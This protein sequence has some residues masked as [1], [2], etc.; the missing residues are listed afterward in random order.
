MRRM[1]SLE[2]L[3]G[4]ADSRVQAL[5]EGGTLENA[6]PIYYHGVDLYDDTLKQSIQLHILN[7]SSE[8]INSVAKIKAWAESITGQ[9]NIQCSGIVYVSDA[10]QV[11]FIIIKFDNNTYQYAY[12]TNSGVKLATPTD[13]N[14]ETYRV[15]DA[16]NKIN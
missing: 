8:P 7:N 1:F 3:K 14:D 5:V 10:Y 2:Q 4:I 12:G 9:V 6:K 13:F 16:L 15:T 11:P